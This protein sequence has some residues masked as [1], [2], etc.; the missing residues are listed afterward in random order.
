MTYFQFLAKSAGRQYFH[1]LKIN[2]PDYMV[3]GHLDDGNPL[4]QMEELA[5]MYGLS[6][7][8]KGNTIYA[9]TQ[10]QFGNLPS[11]EF[12]YRLKYLRPSDMEQIKELIRPMLYPWHWHRKFRTEDEH[13][14]HHRHGHANRSDTES[15]SRN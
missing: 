5:F 1:N 3:T 14:N 11:S 13:G 8:T 6:L 4:N 2:G 9:L 12:H 15:S 10:A 7:H